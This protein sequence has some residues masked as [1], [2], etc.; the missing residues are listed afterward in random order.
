MEWRD[1]GWRVK[2]EGR[3]GWME[4]EGVQSLSHSISILQGGCCRNWNW[5]LNKICRLFMVSA[6]PPKPRKWEPLRVWDI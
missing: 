3:D 6:L 5:A 1:D 4:D 2:G